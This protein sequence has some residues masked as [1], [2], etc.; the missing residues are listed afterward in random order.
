MWD[1]CS[2]LGTLII[3]FGVVPVDRMLVFF[4]NRLVWL[5]LPGGGW[6]FE[7]YRD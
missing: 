6:V 1:G 7:G 2:E 3:F 4:R 5:S